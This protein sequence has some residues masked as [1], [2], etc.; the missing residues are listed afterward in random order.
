MP[1]VFNT[2]LADAGIAPRD[3]RLL[4][5]ETKRHGRTPYSLWRD[6]LNGF[7]DYQRVQK[8]S[9][10]SYFA[11][12]FWAAF[13]VEPGGKTLFAGLS[14]VSSAGAISDGWLDPI[15]GRDTALL[16]DYEL[17]ELVRQEAL[18]CFVGRLVIDWGGGTRTWAQRADKQDKTILAWRESFAEPAFPGHLAFVAQL[19][20]LAALPNGWRAALAAA[21]G[22]YLLTCPRTHEQYVGAA[23]GVE[24][25]LGRWTDYVE[26]GHGGNV[27]LKSR[28]PADYQV[29]ILQVAGSAEDRADIEATEAL[30]KVKLQSRDMGLN[31]N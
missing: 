1:L 18:S 27:G 3:V 17:Y 6:D 24:G 30:W 4:R 29:S 26:T 2:L 13:V 31:R 28:D 7:D 12:P 20:D 14:A 22:V 15:S 23:T 11:S 19:S 9:R 21:R 16:V 10:R 25:F 8:R 5:H